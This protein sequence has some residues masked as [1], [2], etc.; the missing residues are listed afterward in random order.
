MRSFIFAAHLVVCGLMLSSGGCQRKG[1][2]VAMPPPTATQDASTDASAAGTVTM[3]F[4][5][6]ND[7]VTTWEIK[8]IQPG[9]TVLDAM[10]K[11]ESPEIVI[12][13]EG[14]NAFVSSIG[15]LSTTAGEGWSY[16]VNG[17]WADR[18]VGVYKIKPGDKIVWS[19]GGFEPP[20]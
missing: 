17:Q 11:V 13:G 9:D 5:W 6:D 16:S 8:G 3:E 10:R 12:Q 14:P 4:T 7:K 18:S 1:N 20:Q 2:E 15:E 19:H